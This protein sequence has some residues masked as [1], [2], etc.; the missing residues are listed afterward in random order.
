MGADVRKKGFTPED[1]Q[2]LTRAMLEKLDRKQIDEALEGALS[3][4]RKRLDAAPPEN[5][6]K[7]LES[8]AN[9]AR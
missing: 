5:R 1:R 6:G 3:T 4:L 2:A 7:S 9:R 8:A